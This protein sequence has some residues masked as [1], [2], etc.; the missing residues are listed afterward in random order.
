MLE[1]IQSDRLLAMT[2]R[3]KRWLDN[4]KK[5]F[6]QSDLALQS[7]TPEDECLAEL[8]KAI[9]TAKTLRRSLRGEDASHSQNKKRFIEFLGLEIPMARPGES[10]WT[11]VLKDGST[12]SYHFGEIVYDIRCM[13]HENENLNVAEDVDHHIL[14]DWSQPHP[15]I[16]ANQINGTFVC[17]GYFLW[18]RLRQVLAKFI[19]GIDGSISFATN[20][21]FSITIEPE[22]GSIAPERKPRTKPVT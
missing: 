2:D 20:G 5:A 11:L 9:D 18:N 12:K 19:T 7:G 13:V 16:F 6:Q 10:E 17:N 21:S 15:Q 3:E 8:F 1:G 4:V 22:M 14:L